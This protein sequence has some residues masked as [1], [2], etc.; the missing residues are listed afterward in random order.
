[1]VARKSLESASE[2]QNLGNRPGSSAKDVPDPNSYIA[3]NVRTASEKSPVGHRGAPPPIPRQ[4]ERKSAE[5]SRAPP[6]IPPPIPST[7]APPLPY[8]VHR[9][10]SATAGPYTPKQEY[11]DDDLYT[12]S[13]IRKSLD[14]SSFSHV[15][16]PILPSSPH[17]AA[18]QASPRPSRD[19][20]QAS[21]GLGRKSMDH[22]RVMNE[23]EY[24][25]SDV[26]LE[27]SSKWWTQPNS[28]PPVF[29]DRNDILYE[30]EESAGRGERMSIKMKNLY[31][32]YRDYSQTII[33]VEYDNRNVHGVRLVQQHNPPPP[34]LRQ[35]QLEEAHSR[36]G[37]RLSEAVTAK[38]NTVVG[39]GSP[40]ALV[41]DL[42]K[43]MPSALWPVGTRAYG[44]LVY[45]NIANATVQQ[46]DEIRAGDIL[47]LRNAKLQG[48]HGTM[49]Q[50]YAIEVGKPDH[51]GVVVDW[52]GTKK[53][54][55]AWGQGRESKKV[56]IE[57]YRI[58]D[59]KS[60]E[61]RVW[62]VMSRS[63]VGWGSNQ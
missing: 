48:K 13:P 51:V 45:A 1:M 50:K 63:W 23:Q 12:S 8:T 7:A 27:M 57:S 17:P 47:T 26:D 20:S 49:H 3:S 53:K 59:L 39:D 30:I 55:R 34:R 19:Y 38:Q 29:R 58:G 35:D 40:Q 16:S 24:I 18:G 36:F 6:S 37:L 46:Y 4:S 10:N 9:Q 15:R 41:M 54:V 5:I 60:G 32:L 33:S 62:R 28:L 52:D 14:K 31:V 22:S 2:E 61:V 21:G 25:A 44:A 42:L 56:K 43:G 11:D